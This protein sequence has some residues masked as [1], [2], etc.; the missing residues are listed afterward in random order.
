MTFIMGDVVCYWDGG[1]S[2]TVE[3]NMR[4]V[5]N[6]NLLIEA[7]AREESEHCAFN[8]A[9]LRTTFKLMDLLIAKGMEGEAAFRCALDLIVD[10]R[11]NRRKSILG[12][13]LPKALFAA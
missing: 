3:Q 8:L 12:L 9:W 6:C 11:G 4:N 10:A 1:A 5:E 2:H 13:R 7:I